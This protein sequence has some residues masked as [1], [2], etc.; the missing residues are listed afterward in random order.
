ML[1]HQIHAAK[2]QK[3]ISYLFTTRN[4]SQF[5]ENTKPQ[6]NFTDNTALMSTNFT[7]IDVTHKVFNINSD[8][9]FY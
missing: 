9:K 1:L 5:Q 3:K 4:Y 8:A 6:A 2:I 7:N